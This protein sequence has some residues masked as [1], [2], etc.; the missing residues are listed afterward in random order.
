MRSFDP[1][2]RWDPNKLREKIAR[3]LADGMKNPRQLRSSYR[4][5]HD[6][7][8][9]SNDN[10]TSSDDESIPPEIR[11]LNEKHATVMVGGKFAVMNEE[12]YPGEEH[13]RLSFSPAS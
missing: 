13:Q 11:E 9:A 1:R 4:P 3:G 2:N 7:G 12:R 5:I 8:P 6:Q 10:R